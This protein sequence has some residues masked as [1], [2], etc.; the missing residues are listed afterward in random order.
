MNRL[1]YDPSPNFYQRTWW[2]VNFTWEG[3]VLLSFCNSCYDRS[4]RT[5]HVTSLTYFGYSSRIVSL[6]WLTQILF[7]RSKRLTQRLSFHGSKVRP[8]T[9]KAVFVWLKIVYYVSAWESKQFHSRA[10]AVK[11]FSRS[12]LRARGLDPALYGSYNFFPFSAS[13]LILLLAA[14]TFRPH[15]NGIYHKKI[16]LFVETTLIYEMYLHDN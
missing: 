8:R 10:W 6:P 15:R 16:I 5:V 14:P 2:G 9:H 3:H 7:P 1:S 12:I 13:F 4:G 11:I